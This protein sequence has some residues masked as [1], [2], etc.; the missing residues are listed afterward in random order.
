M[1]TRRS[2]RHR[3]AREPAT[4]KGSRDGR[5]QAGPADTAGS[6]LGVKRSGVRISPARRSEAP[7]TAGASPLFSPGRAR[8]QGPIRA[9]GCNRCA[10]SHQ[11]PHRT[12]QVTGGVKRLNSPSGGCLRS[13]LSLRRLLRDAQH[14]ADLRPGPPRRSGFSDRGGEFGIDL[15][16]LLCKLGDVVQRISVNR[17]EIRRFHVVGPFLERCG[18]VGSVLAHGVHHPFRN[19]GRAGIA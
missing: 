14:G 1:T 5:P 9:R 18:P 17:A 3:S 10:L 7:A 13:V 2:G 12:H 6:R 4:T 16:S 19:L 15:V 11:V 8:P